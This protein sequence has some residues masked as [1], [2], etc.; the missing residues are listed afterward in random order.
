ML[1]SVSFALAWFLVLAQGLMILGCLWVM[2]RLKQ[3]YD[4][5]HQPLLT[6]D[7]P[8]LR[9]FV[10]PFDFQNVRTEA[11]TSLW[12]YLASGPA[13]LLFVS[14]KCGPCSDV[15]TSAAAFHRSWIQKTRY[16]IIANMAMEEVRAL[17]DQYPDFDIV[18]DSEGLIAR[19]YRVQR[20]PLGIVVD[21][22]GVVLNKGIVNTPQHLE[23]LV[24][25][26][27]KAMEDVFM[28]SESQDKAL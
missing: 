28:L 6:D 8:P 1:F 7:G 4:P 20:W 16:L 25:G 3:Q 15:L 5:M 21:T 10:E 18:A 14:D 11:Q 13:V 2:G 24:M 9:H 23:G 22:M 19:S 27:G 17:G 26:R 12:E